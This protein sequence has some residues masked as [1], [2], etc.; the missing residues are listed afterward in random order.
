MAPIRQPRAAL[1]RVSIPWPS[2]AC[3]GSSPQ[4]RL[5]KSLRKRM[6]GKLVPNCLRRQRTF[7]LGFQVHIHEVHPRVIAVVRIDFHFD[8]QSECPVSCRAFAG[9]CNQLPKRQFCASRSDIAELFKDPIRPVLVMARSALAP[10]SLAQ[11]K[12]TLNFPL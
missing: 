12:L 8:P 5:P 4:R 1:A 7:A 10:I 11:S 2:R 9:D 6:G 3:E